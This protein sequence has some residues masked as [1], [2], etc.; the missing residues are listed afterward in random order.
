MIDVFAAGATLTPAL[1]ASGRG[2][3]KRYRESSLSRF[4]GEGGAERRVRVYADFAM[5][6]SAMLR[7]TGS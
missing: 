5:I 6:S 4:A 7:G 3:S 2:R 1:P